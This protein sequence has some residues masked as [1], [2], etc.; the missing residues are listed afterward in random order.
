MECLGLGLR[1]STD[2]AFMDAQRVNEGGAKATD[3]LG[4]SMGRIGMGGRDMGKT[5]LSV[6][7]SPISLWYSDL[8][9]DA[10][11]PSYPN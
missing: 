9:L 8:S 1:Q 11:A 7:A 2:S 5:R 3:S 4:T 10:G 6:W